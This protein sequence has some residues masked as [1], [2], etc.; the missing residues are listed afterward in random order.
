MS[1]TIRTQ[2]AA[3]I[4]Q[5]FCA[6]VSFLCSS[7]IVIGVVR[8]EGGLK[9]PFRRLIFGISISDIIQSSSLII[10]PFAIPASDISPFGVGSQGTCSAQGFVVDVTGHTLPVYACAISYFYC[11]K[12]HRN[13]SNKE[14]SRRRE[15]LAHF[16][17]LTFGL[18][19]GTI[20]IATESMNPYITGTFC[21]Y[22]TSPRDCHR[23]PE[24][25]GPGECKGGN[26]VF[27]LEMTF[28][29]LVVVCQVCIIR[30]VT[31]ILLQMVDRDRRYGVAT[32]HSLVSR[33]A[34]S[35]NEPTDLANPNDGESGETGP[36]G[37]QDSNNRHDGS[38]QV[39]SDSPQ[40]DRSDELL[41][42]IRK[43]MRT[44]ALLYV[45]A[46]FVTYSMLWSY[47]LIFMLG[48]IPPPLLLVLAELFG[49]LGG[50]FNLLVFTRPSVWVLRRRYSYSWPEALVLVVKAGGTIPPS[51]RK[52]EEEAYGG[53]PPN[54]LRD[55]IHSDLC[56]S[57]EAMI[58]N[59]SAPETPAL[60]LLSSV[61][62]N[63]A[64]ES[65]PGYR[66][67]Y[68]N[69]AEIVFL[70]PSQHTTGR[71]QNEDLA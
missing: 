4:T 49:S 63:S 39:R 58:R 50:L 12:L 24:L 45:G 33:T 37:P 32:R 22:A 26:T 54:H 16:S 56:P 28:V 21:S 55:E 40:E 13:M 48:S 23:H 38:N 71:Q 25:Y 52:K 60:M 31:L 62:R 29:I 51:H 9:S 1:T 53:H 59:L 70:H 42:S 10:A 11:C 15:W 2:Q 69:I 67:F 35:A 44:Q 14:F 66:Q 65:M 46:F 47:V 68:S 19:V 18:I 7:A 8:S 5:I 30:N 41:A 27:A 3:A 43:T 64:D 34:L 17:G 57:K 6:A 61:P 36:S 20:A